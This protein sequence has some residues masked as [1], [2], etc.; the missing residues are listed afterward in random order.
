MI[1]TGKKPLAV[2]TPF[3]GELLAVCEPFLS[4]VKP[5][6]SAAI[7]Y[8]D[9][10]FYYINDENITYLLMTRPTYPKV[11]AIGCIESVRKEIKNV[12]YGMN[13][14]EISDYGLNEK[15]KEKLKMKFEYFNENTEVTSESLEKLK[16]ELKLMKE[17]VYKANEQLL[18]RSEKIN[19][20]ENKAEKMVESS[21]TY[22]IRAIKVNKKESKR[23]VCVYILVILVILLIIY[24]IICFSCNS[25]VFDC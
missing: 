24:G 25:F 11:T 5:N 12:I 8:G 1:A 10:I 13:L 4:K 23:K 3:V 19:E 16:I 2:Y 15:L 6:S 21:E 17:E 18:I 7:N 9:Y 22:K 14:D 20:M